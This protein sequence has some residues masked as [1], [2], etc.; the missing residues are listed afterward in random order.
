MEERREGERE[1]CRLARLKLQST[2]AKTSSAQA[3]SGVPGG[4]E[5]PLGLRPQGQEAWAQEQQGKVKAF[6]LRPRQSH[7]GKSQDKAT[8]PQATLP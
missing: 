1:P 6:P 5:M 8:S 2:Q 7:P 3:S 4:L